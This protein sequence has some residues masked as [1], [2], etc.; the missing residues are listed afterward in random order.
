M[1]PEVRTYPGVPPVGAF[2]A[3]DGTPIVINTATDTPYYLK[4]PGDVVTP[5]AGGG[6]GTGTVTHTVGALTN[7][8]LTIGSGV[9]VDDIK[10]IAAMTDGQIVVGATG[11]DPAPQTVSGDATLSAAGVLTIAPSFNASAVHRL[12]GGL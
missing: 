5:F 11:A 7:H 1:S 12:F 6:G 9:S 4:S 10:T 3:T 2:G 8:A